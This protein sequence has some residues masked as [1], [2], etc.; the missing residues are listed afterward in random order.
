VA[1]LIRPTPSGE[2]S[3]ISIP[4]KVFMTSKNGPHPLMRAVFD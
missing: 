4:I 1:G 3:P 2:P